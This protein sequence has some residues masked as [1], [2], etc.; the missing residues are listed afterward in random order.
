[1]KKI[2]KRLVSVMLALAIVLTGMVIPSDAKAATKGLY[3]GYDTYEDW[4]ESMGLGAGGVKVS[5]SDVSQSPSGVTEDGEFIYATYYELAKTYGFVIPTDCGKILV[6]SGGYPY[7]GYK[8][9]GTKVRIYD[10]DGYDALGYD[11]KYKDKSGNDL[12]DFNINTDNKLYVEFNSL[13]HSK[14]NTDIV[15]NDSRA[16]YMI[17]SQD[18]KMQFKIANVEYNGKTVPKKDY[19][20]NIKTIAKSKDS[21]GIYDVT[22]KANAKYNNAKWSSR[23]IVMPVL[24]I[25]ADISD[26]AFYVSTYFVSNLPSPKNIYTVEYTV[27]KSTKTKTITSKG[28][29]IKVAVIN[30]KNDKIVK[31]GKV[32]LKNGDDK[33]LYDIGKKNKPG[34]WYYIKYRNSVKAGKKTIYSDWIIGGYYYSINGKNR[35]VITNEN[36]VLLTGRIS[37]L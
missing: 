17:D 24:G 2:T 6:N 23:V 19:T 13:C 22:V 7:M 21:A 1:M 16:I 9:D 29:K 27:Y 3:Y 35:T 30:N 11:S 28:K 25:I 8:T 14:N 37:W 33:K 10:K 5:P 32:S 18:P 4:A 34:E 12:L 26:N 20:V 36:N 31:K 15:L